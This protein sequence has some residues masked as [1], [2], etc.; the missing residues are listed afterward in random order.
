M[1]KRSTSAHVL[2]AEPRTEGD[3]KNLDKNRFRV[4]QV[5][6]GPDPSMFSPVRNLRTLLNQARMCGVRAKV[7]TQPAFAQPAR[8]S[9]LPFCLFH[10]NGAVEL[11]HDAAF[12]S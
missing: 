10:T 9:A 6:S 8:K 12:Q 3:E 2:A 1:P 7:R 5:A 4:K 11:A